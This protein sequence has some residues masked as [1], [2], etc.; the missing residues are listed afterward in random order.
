MR[1]VITIVDDN[2]N[3]TGTYQL[4]PA[5]IIE[6]DLYTKYVFAFEFNELNYDKKENPDHD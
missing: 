4:A 6:C 1:A 3:A 2:D 5:N